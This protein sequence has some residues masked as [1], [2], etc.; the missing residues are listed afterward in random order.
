[1]IYQCVNCKRQCDEQIPKCAKCGTDS[2]YPM[3]GSESEKPKH[4]HYFREWKG[5]KLDFYFIMTLFG[6]TDPC[7]MHAMKKLMFAGVRGAKGEE[8]DLN[9]AIDS[10]RRRLELMKAFDDRVSA[11]FTR[12]TM[13]PISPGIMRQFKESCRPGSAHK[14]TTET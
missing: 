12:E 8:K 1:M 3:R 13:G 5:E 6:I 10:I 4:S 11:T 2:V 14:N 7:L 9:E